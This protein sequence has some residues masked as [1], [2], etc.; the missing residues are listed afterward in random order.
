MA[1]W[2]G[3]C[4]QSSHMGV[5]IPSWP[6]GDNMLFHDDSLTKSVSSP[7]YNYIFNKQTGFFARWGKTKEDDPAFAPAPEILDMEISAGGDCLGKCEF[8]YKGNGVGETHNM[9]FD[10]F[11]IIFDKLP[12]ILTQIAF[13]IMNISTNPDFFDMMA[14]A[15]A[16]GVIP[17]YTCHGLDVTQEDA[18]FTARTCGAVAV[19]LYDRQKSYN[20]IKM[21]LA[22]GM[23]QVNIHH[24]LAKETYDAAFDILDEVAADPDLQ[25]LNAIVFLQ[26][27]KKGRALGQGFNYLGSVDKYRKLID[28]AQE[29]KIGIGFDSCSAPIFM[30][31]VENQPDFKQLVMLAEPCESTLFSA[32]INCRGQF[33]PCSFAEGIDTWQTGIDVLSCNDFVKDVWHNERTEEFRKQLSASSSK[34]NCQ[35]KTYCRHCPIYEGV[36]ACES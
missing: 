8:C 16:K 12:P 24:L 25:G 29:K 4:L 26:L 21:F 27:K 13:G 36:T 32:Y 34:C 1:E 9:T 15:Q 19:S 23:K 14:Y 22:A 5:R 35:H 18:E 10:E 6:K 17:N 33:F 31:S 28:Y 2:I 11:K 7:D 20:A 30:K 3:G